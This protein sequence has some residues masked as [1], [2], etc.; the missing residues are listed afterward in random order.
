MPTAIIAGL[1][2]DIERRVRP[3]VDRDR[4]LSPDWAI[5][6][7]RSKS[8][9]PGLAPSQFAGVNQVASEN[10]GAHVLVF[11][12]RDRSMH[13]MFSAQVA[14]Y[15][16]VRWIETSLLRLIPHSTEEFLR[17]IAQ[18]LSEELEWDLNVKPKDESC[19]L[20]LPDAHSQRMGKCSRF[21]QLR[22]KLG[23][24][25]SVQLR[26]LW[27]TFGGCIGLFTGTESADGSIGTAESLIIWDRVA[28]ELHH[29]LGLGNSR[30]CR[31]PDFTSI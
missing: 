4:P 13:T 19:C 17:E 28:D 20:L 26:E 12:G 3:I 9:V 22:A 15:F 27:S 23:R 18:I 5:K 14:N 7:F 16:R 24:I 6:W 30:T 21:G 1:P 31:A 29:F 11:R 8:K 25:E 2:P 10:D